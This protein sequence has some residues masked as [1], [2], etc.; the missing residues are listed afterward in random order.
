MLM[1]NALMC[2]IGSNRGATTCN[3]ARPSAVGAAY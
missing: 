3:I 1:V 2:N